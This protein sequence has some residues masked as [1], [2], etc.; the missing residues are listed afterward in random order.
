MQG[1]NW[2]DLKVFLVAAQSTSL[3]AAAEQLNINSTTISRRITALET[4][5]NADLFDRSK[6]QWR[7]TPFG[8]GI[9]QQASPMLQQAQQMNRYVQAHTQELSGTLRLTAPDAC[10]SSILLPLIQEFEK[11]HPH[12]QLELIA[13]TER[14]NLET[15]EA[16]VAFRVTDKPPEDLVGSHI[17][18]FGIAVYGCADNLKQLELQDK[19]LVTCLGWE[20]TEPMDWV[21]RDIGDRAKLIHTN[22]VSTLVEM[23][24]AGVGL[25]QF[26]CVL[27][28]PVP[29]LQRLPG[30]YYLS[31]YG[32]WML[33]HIGVRTSAKVKIFRE[34]AIEKLRAQKAAIEGN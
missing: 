23:T 25:G 4:Q 10:F 27:G 20:A 5:L 33:T 21:T 8:E 9:F 18:Q 29:Q 17:G 31:K 13:T 26:Y 32:F 2:D 3:T 30:S 28:D 34:F 14:L 11:L 16:D 24:K 7:L 1:L 6:R 12:I 22:S 19:S 15:A